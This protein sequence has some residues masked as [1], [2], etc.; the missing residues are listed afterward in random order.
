MYVCAVDFFPLFNRML[1]SLEIALS[2][3][4]SVIEKSC[5]CLVVLFFGKYA[6]SSGFHFFMLRRIR[7]GQ[8]DM[9]LQYFQA[10]AM[11]IVLLLPP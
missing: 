4:E 8:M 2:L 6:T 9:L 7:N 11:Y 3:D 1:C 10:F 5:L